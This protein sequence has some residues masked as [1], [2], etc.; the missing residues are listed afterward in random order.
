MSGSHSGNQLNLEV[1]AAG[2]APATFKGT[3]ESATRITGPVSGSGFNGQI[4][5]L[6]K[7]P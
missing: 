2:F 7:Q 6:S 4:L 5:V 3:V 1:Y